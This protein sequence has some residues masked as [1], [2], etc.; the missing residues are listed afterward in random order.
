MVESL[1]FKIVFLFQQCQSSFPCTVCKNAIHESNSNSLEL[2]LGSI[3]SCILLLEI[4]H[5]L[6]HFEQ[7]YK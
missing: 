7:I 6:K 5:I 2:L 3:T 4:Q 1:A